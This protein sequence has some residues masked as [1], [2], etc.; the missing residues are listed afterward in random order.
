MSN[1][2]QMLQDLEPS[3]EEFHIAVIAGLRETPR[4]LPCKFLYDAEGSRLF[5]RICELP[6]YYPTRTE[7]RILM[8]HAGDIADE[9]RRQEG[10]GGRGGKKDGVHS[11]DGV[12]HLRH[13]HLTLEIGNGT[14]SLHDEVAVL[15]AGEI[16]HQAI[17]HGDAHGGQVG[18][19]FVQHRLA[20]GEVE[21]RLA[22]L[23]VAHRR[24]HDL[25]EQHHGRLDDLEVAVVE[26][27]ERPRIEDLGQALHSITAGTA[28]SANV[29]TVVP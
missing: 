8:D 14:E 11:A 20:L 10:V 22:L 15:G 9:T 2:L 17:E 29:T 27:V 18:E 16:N 26:R 7:C 3:T 24:H 21:E 6:E 12:V 4:T 23:R 25:V 5:D 1:A 13:L 19:R 28:R